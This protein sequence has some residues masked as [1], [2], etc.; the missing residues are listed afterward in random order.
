MLRKIVWQVGLMMVLAPSLWAQDYKVEF[1]GNLG[2]TFS[3]GFTINPVAIGGA[4]YDKIN[5]TS[6]VSY[7]FTVGVF[8]TENVEIG[9]LYGRQDSA[10]EAKGTTKR[11]FTDMKV[12]NYH[13]IF[14]YNFGY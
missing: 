1:S 13:G 10:L 4:V 14:T 5:P 12:H 9:F 6:G 2:Y 7:N 11:E 8:V 3:E